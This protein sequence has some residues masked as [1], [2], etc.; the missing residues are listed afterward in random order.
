[1]EC[2]AVFLIDWH[3]ATSKVPKVATKPI[4]VEGGHPALIS[5]TG[6]TQDFE[7]CPL[8]YQALISNAKQRIWISSPYLVPDHATMTALIFA[9]KRGVD[10]RIMIPQ[11]KDH[12]IVYLAA[13][14]YYEK[15]TEAGIKILRYGPGFLHQKAVLVDDAIAGIGT[16]N[17][18]QRAFHLNFEVMAF[19]TDPEFVK[20]TT[21][22]LIQDMENCV[23][24]TADD[25]NKRGLPFRICVRVCRM[26]SPLL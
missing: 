22:M 23:P 2:Q 18:D 20:A 6:P 5:P 21:E 10:V 11:K 7:V 1:M 14:S 19:C 25:Y 26:F 12:L 4:P 13:F 24:G 8:L 3:W 9:A 17:L 16:V 15:L